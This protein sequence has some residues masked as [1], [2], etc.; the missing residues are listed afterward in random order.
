M[1]SLHWR[2]C[3]RQ[4]TLALVLTPLVVIVHAH[5]A[6]AQLTQASLKGSKSTQ[7]FD[8]RTIQIGAR[9]LF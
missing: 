4:R 1:H 8:P 3:I 9:L 2:R 6:F 5:A 7:A